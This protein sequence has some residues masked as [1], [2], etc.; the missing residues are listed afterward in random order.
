MFILL[1]RCPPVVDQAA[2]EDVKKRKQAHVD[3]SKLIPLNVMKKASWLS[4]TPVIECV[5]S[6][7]APHADLL[8]DM[9]TAQFLRELP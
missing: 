3:R 2:V 9:V 7:Q 5:E 4:I 8:T 1:S 6:M